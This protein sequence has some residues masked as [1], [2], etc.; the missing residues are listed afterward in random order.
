M[1]RR[2]HHERRACDK[3]AQKPSRHGLC[4]AL[5]NDFHWK[6]LIS[7]LAVHACIC[8]AVWC[9]VN[10]QAYSGQVFLSYAHG[11]CVQGYSFI[12]VAF[13]VLLYLLYLTECWHHREKFHR[14]EKADTEEVEEYV[15][16]MRSATPVVWWKS[17]CYHYLRRT[18]Q[19]TRYRNGDA[20]TA[21]QVFYERVNSHTS[22]NVYLYD[23]CGVRDISK[24]LVHLEKYPVIKV[25]F[26]K[27]FVFACVQAANEFEEQRARFF[28]ENEVKD[29]YMEVR[30]GLD[31][32]ECPFVEQMLVF[33]N[34]GQKAPWY[35]SDTAYW[36]ASVLLWSWPLRMIAEWRTAH[37]HYQVTKLFGTNYLSPSSVNYTGPLTRTSTMD[38]SELEIANRQNY[39]IVPSYSEAILLDPVTTIVQPTR[40]GI[41][42]DFRM[43]NEPLVTCNENTVITNYGAVNGDAERAAPPPF[44]TNHN[45]PL[46]F[47]RNGL[48]RVQPREQQEQQLRAPSRSHSM[49]L[50]S[51]GS[52]R[53]QRPPVSSAAVPVPR[54]CQLPV[55]AGPPRSISISGICGVP[56]SGGPSSGFERSSGYATLADESPTTSE[57]RPLIEPFRIIDEPPPPYEVALRT[58]AP[59][60]N[61][62]RQ[63]AHS[64]SSLL[65]A[66]SHS[67]SKDFRNLDAPGTSKDSY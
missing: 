19:V 3:S 55:G 64:I 37:L 17:V 44:S 21:T 12:P 60:Y 7:T 57:R 20:I 45:G 46:S 2:R 62:L 33:A 67:N 47:L 5:R 26:S 35:L 14:M 4:T 63:S 61:R 30:E 51:S 48:S 59:I 1:S 15:Q 23:Q 24:D 16:R 53:S 22:G 10:H 36:A 6:C 38:S 34:P 65:N 43:R 11:P 49:S 50:L 40:F 31:L 54:P 13:G 9:H 28:S 42:S 29:D 66:L 32:A 27:G 8:Y 41:R 58:F 25:R 39:L 56:G 18:R 52:F